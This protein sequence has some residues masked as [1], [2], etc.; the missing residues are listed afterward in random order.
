MDYNDFNHR[1]KAVIDYNEFNHRLG[2]YES[3]HFLPEDGV[4][5]LYPSVKDFLTFQ[6]LKG[7]VESFNSE[8]DSQHN[9]EK[10]II[11]LAVGSECEIFCLKEDF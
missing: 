1:L 8:L 11:R 7:N 6:K 2:A 3:G 10:I 9:L 5:I 4:A